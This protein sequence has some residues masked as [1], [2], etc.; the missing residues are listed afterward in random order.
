MPPHAATAFL[1]VPPHAATRPM[2]NREEAM[3]RHSLYSEWRN[4]LPPKMLFCSITF[5]LDFSL[6]PSALGVA[7]HKADLREQ[8]GSECHC[9]FP[10]GHI[11]SWCPVQNK[12]CNGHG[13]T[14]NNE[15]A[16]FYLV[17]CVRPDGAW[18]ESTIVAA[19]L[20]THTGNMLEPVWNLRPHL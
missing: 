18:P 1:W 19:Q 9:Y 8:C 16:E 20:V 4:L 15:A 11:T 2:Q 10:W 7:C 12:G 3:L 17:R 13:V 5:S 14:E 6:Q